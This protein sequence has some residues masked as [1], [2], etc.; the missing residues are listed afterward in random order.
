MGA[1]KK[2]E[3]HLAERQ[4]IAYAAWHGWAAS[5]EPGQSQS[6]GEQWFGPTPEAGKM[7]YLWGW[8]VSLGGVGK[9][10]SWH[11]I[12]AWSEL[13]GI[14]PTP[15]ECETM[16]KMSNIFASE[17]QAGHKKGANVPVIAQEYIQW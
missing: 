15:V 14:T 8:I 6:R 5:T 10:L 17:L 16:I 4:A 11:E 2:A 12:K 7:A 1:G 13:S 3:G 9:N